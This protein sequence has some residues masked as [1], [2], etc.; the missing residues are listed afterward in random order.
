[1]WAGRITHQ[2]NIQLLLAIL[3]N[4][5]Q[6]DFHIWGDSD[7]PMLMAA[8]DDVA[9]S[10]D[11]VFLNGGFDRFE[12]LPLPSYDV[13]L[14]TSLWDGLPN[15]LLEAA[16]SGLPIVASESGGIAELVDDTTGW[17]VPP[18][19]Q[20]PG[21]IAALR[22]AVY[23]PETAYLRAIAMQR[24]LVEHHNWRSYKTVLTQQPSATGGLLSG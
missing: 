22:E 13:F 11:N 6:F 10:R 2:K 1:L 17:L 7:D 21:F 24:R 8:L 4:A 12:D 19:H 15:V 18:A 5:P 16:A 3:Q 14:Y 9:R 20:A 23:N